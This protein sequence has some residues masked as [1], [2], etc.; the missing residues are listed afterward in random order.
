MKVDNKK[1]ENIVTADR[2]DKGFAAKRAVDEAVKVKK[3]QS[4]SSI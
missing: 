3:S 2:V 4:A 1:K